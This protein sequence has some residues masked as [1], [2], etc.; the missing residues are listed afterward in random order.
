MKFI[1]HLELNKLQRISKDVILLYAVNKRWASENR[2]ITTFILVCL[3]QK[4]LTP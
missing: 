3:L 1:F 4:L 2:L